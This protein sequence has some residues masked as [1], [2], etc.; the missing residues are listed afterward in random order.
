[1]LGVACAVSALCGSLLVGDSVRASLRE[2]FLRRLGRAEHAL[3]SAR[4]FREALAAEVT[5]EAAPLLVLEGALTHEGSGRRAAR[6]TVYGVDRRFWAFHGLAD[7]SL[8]GREAQASAPLAEELLA[9][10]G[11]ALLLRVAFPSDIPGAS[12]FGRRDDSGRS[13]RLTLEGVRTASELGE[14]SLQARQQPVLA[15]FVPLELLQ[16]TLEREAQVN[17][18]LLAEAAAPAEAPRRLADVERLVRGS[19]RLEDLGLRLRPLPARHA[20]SLESATGLLGEEVSAAARAAAGRLG[21]PAAGY[22]TYLANAIKA[23][24]RT[25]PYSLVTAR[26]AGSA[27][28]PARERPP[29]LSPPPIWLNDWAARDLGAAAGDRVVLEYYVWLEA[30]RLE[31]R[32]A[33]FELAG[34][35]PLTPASADPDLTPEYPGITGTAHL[36]DWDPPFPLSLAAI[37]PRDED[38]W[39]RYRT[40]PKAFVELE[41]GQSLWRHR[42]GALTSLRVEPPR[43]TSLEEAEGGLRAELARE[44]DPLALGLRLVPVRANGLAASAGAT[45]FGEY[46]AYFSAFLVASALLL[47]GLFFRLGVEQRRRE[48][49]LLRALG[50]P[51]RRVLLLFM[52]EGLALAI[53][54]SLLGLV[55]AA[56]VAELMML[57]LRTVWSG[58][59]G[60]QELRLHLTGRALVLGG[61]GGLAAAA[62]VLAITLRGLRRVSPR[63]LLAGGQQPVS[64]PGGARRARGSSLAALLAAGVLLLAAAT[65]R[66]ADTPAFFAAGTLLLA[67]ALL[68]Q[69]SWLAARR[70]GGL[71][72]SVIGLGVR[73]AAHRPG[74]SLLCIALIA[75][76]TFV[77]VAT[78]AFRRQTEP[79][80]GARQSGTGGYALVAEALLPLHHDPGSAEGREKLGL[81]DAPLEGVGFA[82]FRLRP[83]DDASCLNLY[84]PHDPRVLGAT[85]EFVREGRFDF[86]ASLADTPAEQANPWLLL[87]RPSA[88]GAIPAIADANSLAYVLHRSLGDELELDAGGRRVRLRVVAALRDS[89]FQGELLVAERHFQQAFPEIDGY[90]LLLVDAPHERASALARE[91]EARLADQGLDATDAAGLLAGFH[92]VENTYL[93]TFETLGGLGLLLGTVG[94]ATVLLRNALERRRELALLRAVGFRPDSLTRLVAAENVLLLVLGLATGAGCALVAIA[95]ALAARGGRFPWLSLS[96]LLAAVLATGLAASGL[97]AAWVRRAP[98]L[99]AL[100]S[101]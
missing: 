21:F 73:N 7:P 91:L 82:R 74:R 58:A 11:D 92:R 25:I 14:F 31:T 83:G 2:L 87:E 75:F 23:R 32:T 64:R 4:F 15:L 29:T 99:G 1:V 84:R 28:V 59:V 45:D 80:S 41:A 40:T 42:L 20:L 101:E 68:Y 69:W 97:A 35:V 85:P 17:A 36:S 96:A 95:P 100:R 77:I 55:G 37:R 63:A 78:G 49:G 54:G 13:L 62:L 6:V 65:G 46:F 98:L 88:G 67:A 16:R 44:L 22:L 19:A 39:D 79:G 33:E 57:G 53:L 34:S 90:R 76:A 8:S 30:G 70:R 72:S 52:S 5:G 94:L 51:A 27:D 81:D 60:T 66:L 48:L 10:P 86:Q 50:F 93:A 56:G 3:T 89:L 47:A 9:S 24:G 38:Y 71:V 18:L 43:S 26:E 12:I 61:S